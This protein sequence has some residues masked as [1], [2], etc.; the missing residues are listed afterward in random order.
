MIACSSV[1][2]RYGRLTAVEGLDLEVPRGR[3]V[4]MIGPNA[5]GKT[6][7]LGMMCGLIAPTAGGIRVNGLPPTRLPDPAGV[8]GTVL[9]AGAAPGG[10]AVS[11]FLEQVRLVAGAGRERLVRVV[12]ELG[13]GPVAGSPFR[14]CSLGSRR[15]VMLAAA[16]LGRPQYLLLDEPLNGL[17]PTMV[18]WLAGYLRELA[19]RDGVGVLLSSH[20]LDEQSRVC[21]AIVVMGSGRVLAR[22]TLGDVLAAHRAPAVLVGTTPEL[23]GPLASRLRADG[24]DVALRDGACVVAGGSPEALAREVLGA[25]YPLTR[26]ERDVPSLQEAYFALTA[27]HEGL[28]SAGAPSGVDS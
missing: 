9:D 14:A 8:V 22:G 23:L 2:K 27:G 16:L 12:E 26:L 15:R 1:T 17:D 28:R 7:T 21:D 11:E 13:L 3:I 20:L 6:T 18:R 5:A 25:G 4:G 10:V 19:D 24:W